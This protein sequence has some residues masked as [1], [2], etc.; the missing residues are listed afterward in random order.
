VWNSAGVETPVTVFVEVTNTL[1]APYL[2]GLQRLT[3]ELLV[4][5]R[6][7][8]VTGGRLEVV[9]LR[10]CPRHRTLRRL[11]AS[12]QRQLAGT[13]RHPTA[14][15]P[16]RRWVDQLPPSLERSVK[17][18]AR[19]PWVRRTRATLLP[20]DLPPAHP[21]LEVRTLP[22]GSV[23][24][25]VEAA[26]HN[27]RSRAELLPELVAGGVVPVVVVADVFP[28]VHPEWFESAP[29]SLFRSWLRAHLRHS[30]AFLC[31][32]SATEAQLRQVAISI[33]ERRELPCRVVTP[34]ADLP[35]G[36]EVPLPEGLDGVRY[37]LDVS[38]LEPR[39]GHDTLLDAFD[40][41]SPDVADLAL[42]LVGRA[43]WHADALVHRISSHPLAGSRLWWF[44]RVDD[45][46][47]ATLYRHAFLAVTPSRSEGFGVPVVEALGFGVPVVA[48]AAGALPEAGG[49]L[50]EYFPPGDAV[51]LAGLIERHATDR[52]WHDAR[53]RPLATYEPPTWEA[54]AAAVADA[55]S[56]LS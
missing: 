25:D 10:W 1:A 11:T 55:L 7:P 20:R 50:A 49:D 38:T 15:A 17:G 9:P 53:R 43:G 19:Q 2:S 6:D 24:L 42:V 26:W 46:L 16:R 56:D 4:R 3:R 48:S 30:A 35:V 29:A 13:A 45:D 14:A 5:L 21:D 12:E 34:G 27:P 52:W 32:S 37:L 54:M 47:L 28:E 36:T 31:I 39:K 44:D 18:I 33:G 22:R 8:A 51:A 41:V 40:R 23:F